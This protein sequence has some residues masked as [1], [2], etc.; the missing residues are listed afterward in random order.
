M[1]KSERQK[2]EYL[3]GLIRERLSLQASIASS[4]PSKRPYLPSVHIR[5]ALLPRYNMSKRISIWNHVSKKI[6]SDSNVRVRNEEIK[7]EILRVWEWL[8]SPI[9]NYILLREL[10]E[11]LEKRSK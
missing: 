5:E 3:V 9:D 4:N 7:G 8:G 10:D 11:H 1:V 2:Q 6:E